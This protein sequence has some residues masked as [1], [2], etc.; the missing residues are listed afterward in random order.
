MALMKGDYP[1]AE[2]LT[3]RELEW[4]HPL[5]PIGDEASAARFHH[6]LLRREQDRSAESEAGIRVAVE[7][8]PWYPL[9][10][11]AL[12]NLLLDLGRADE[13]RIAFDDLAR[14]EFSAIYRDNE[15][16]LGMAL[17]AEACA[18]LSDV[19]SAEVLYR[20]LLQF[21]GRHAVGQV[22]G[23][24]G[25]ADRY[26]GLLASII[27]DVAAA[28]R[29]LGDAIDINRQMGAR[30]WAAHAQYDLGRVL[31]QHGADGHPE[32]AATLLKEASTRLARWA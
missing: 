31:L 26:L 16:L 25:A 10:R 32:R 12:V 3:T 15:W 30:P 22:E 27:G 6:Y 17:A 24:L 4:S 11:A 18:R 8:F 20:Q 29:H 5:T 7:E 23:S 9:H 13:A 19:K 21:A 2:E 1:L 14:D 28:E